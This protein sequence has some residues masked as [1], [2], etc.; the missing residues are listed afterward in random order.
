LDPR[1]RNQVEALASVGFDVDVICM[2]RPGEPKCEQDGRIT[3]RR[4]PLSDRRSGKLGY[5]AEYS[6]FFALA[7]FSATVLFLRHRHEMV[8]VHSLPDALVFAAAIPKLLGAKVVLDLH[9]CMPEFFATKF[10]VEAKHPAVRAI[11]WLE[12]MSIRMAHL[13]IT[14]NEHMRQRFIHRG[15]DPARI[16]IVMGSADEKRFRP[17]ALSPRRREPGQFTIVS[18]G[19][20]DERYGLDTAIRAVALLKEE[21]PELRLEIY[22]EGPQEPE[23]RL[24]A[25]HLGVKDRVSF[26]GVVRL[27]RLLNAIDEADA[28]LVATKRDAFRDLV[29]CLKMFEFV[30]MRKPV[31]CSRTPAVQACFDEKSFLYFDAA[32]ERDLARAIRQ[33][34][35]NP[36]MAERLIACATAANESFRWPRQRELYLLLMRQVV[37]QRS[38]GLPSSDAPA[39]QS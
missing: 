20:I 26:S 18:H 1:V 35:A 21:I 9:E 12:Q 2:R 8:V 19:T 34:H 15:A 30:S 27:D 6:M 17:R 7:M 14:C 29:L 11:A 38:P 24:L 25:R 23:L 37:A 39:P 5:I 16:A 32:D 4:L 36:H 28:G 3:I 22:G 31:I 33:L 13:T 10:C